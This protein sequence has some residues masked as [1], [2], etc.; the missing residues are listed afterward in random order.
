[1]KINGLRKELADAIGNH[2]EAVARTALS[3]QAVDRAKGYIRSLESEI[4]S[5]AGIE[6]AVAESR[7][8]G[9]KASMIGGGTPSFALSPELQGAVAK[10]TETEATLSAARSAAAALS[11]QHSD[12]I[13]S[14]QE[15]KS[16]LDGA[17]NAVM[18]D[19]IEDLAR[20]IRFFESQVMALRAKLHGASKVW[21][22]LNG[23][24]A[25]ARFTLPRLAVETLHAKSARE[26]IESLNSAAHKDAIAKADRWRAYFAELQ[27]DANAL[28]DP[29]AG[30]GPVSERLRSL[31][32]LPAP[33]RMSAD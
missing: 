13:A 19:E 20:E 16:D 15:A 7:A 23:S 8:E 12:A 21:I 6:S 9:I 10:R 3:A 22:V 26:E 33:A 5:F 30:G 1:M 32:N 14:E 25:P 28:F 11:G 4:E 29:E 24:R 27:S 17:V 31:F 2:G 18:L